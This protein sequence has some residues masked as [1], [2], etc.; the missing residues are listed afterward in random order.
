[1]KNKITIIGEDIIGC[2]GQDHTGALKE[3]GVEYTYNGSGLLDPNICQMIWKV[4]LDF[5]IRHG[6]LNDVIYE[7]HYK[8]SPEYIKYWQEGKEAFLAGKDDPCDN[9]YTDSDMSDPGYWKDV[10][11]WKGYPWYDGFRET[12]AET[13]EKKY[14]LIA[15]QKEIAKVV[16]KYG[17][18]IK[19]TDEYNSPYCVTPEGYN[20]DFA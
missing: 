1:M 13:R 14:K 19:Y 6:L 16:K 18:T 5:V 20:V 9:P 10:L 15:F 17:L 8:G 11:R 12:E 2:D 4:D 3:L 7:Q